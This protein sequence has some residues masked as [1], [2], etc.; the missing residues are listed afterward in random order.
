M[1]AVSAPSSAQ[2][3]RT[4]AL[5]ALLTGTLLGTLTNNVVN[6][7]LNQIARDF[8]ASLED[9]ILV[10]AGF[11]VTFAAS[12]PLAGWLGDRFG[13]RRVYAGALLATAV[14]SAGA[15]TA[16]T[17]HLLIGWRVVGGVAAAAFAPAVMGLITWLFDPHRRARA[18]GTWASVNGMGQAIG[19]SIGGLVAGQWGW[20]W[21]FVPLI[22]IA[23]GGF[24]A[25]LRW[26][27]R[28]PA[29]RLPLDAVG[30]LSL[31][32]GAIALVTATTLF[33]RPDMPVAV[34]V[35]CVCFG[36]LSIS[37][38]VVHCL[39]TTH[40]FVDLRLAAEPI[41]GRSVA[42][43]FAQMFCLSSTLV[44][45]P[46]SVTGGGQSTTYAGL[47][48]FALPAV[49]ATA[50][51]V[52]GRACE[53]FGARAIMRVGLAVLGGAMI[54]LPMA[55]HWTWMLVCALAVAGVGVALVQTPAAA[56]ST[57]SPVG[58]SGSGMGLFNLLRFGGAAIGAA[59]VAVALR[60]GSYPLLFGVSAVIALSALVCS[61]LGRE[62]RVRNPVGN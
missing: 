37:V 14:C 24:V 44:A 50:G 38:F 26:I 59:W 53:R 34:M 7:P 51:P 41:F 22:P 18:I 9:V 33:A 11:L 39:R 6:V 20:R 52:S 47:V 19:P 36:V 32:V 2:E 35:G 46:L 40:P 12:M 13:R 61:W 56:G 27:P 17:L 8:D 60:Y 3:N 1:N 28:Y 45:V 25:T 16:P 23:I 49:M 29:T 10:A 30:S 43:S 4:L 21:V 31:T 5:S 58:A 54:L 42:A 15:A 62:S 48:L 55:S 57:R